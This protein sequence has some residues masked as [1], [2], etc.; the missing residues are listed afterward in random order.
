MHMPN[1]FTGTLQKKLTFGN[2][3]VN[4]F[5]AKEKKSCSTFHRYMGE[6]MYDFETAVGLIR[7]M[8]PIPKVS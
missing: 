2:G 5:E 3:Y 6:F 7:G 1:Q 8:C 4:L